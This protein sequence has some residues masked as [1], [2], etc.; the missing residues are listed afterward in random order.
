MPAR[1]SPDT[2]SCATNLDLLLAPPEFSRHS[3]EAIKNEKE[4]GDRPTTMDPRS[5]FFHSA[6][7]LKNSGETSNRTRGNPI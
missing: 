4:L 7:V 1:M 6:S 2:S 3:K 5:S